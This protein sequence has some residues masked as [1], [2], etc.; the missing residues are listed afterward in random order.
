[1]KAN[2]EFIAFSKKSLSEITSIR[3]G[4]V[5]LGQKLLTMNDELANANYFILGVSEDIGPQS[6]GGFG[7]ST[8]AFSAFLKR[9]V[10]IQSNQFLIGENILVL[11]EIIS[12]VEFQN[13]NDGR[14]LVEE[15]D[16]FV[17]SILSPLIIKGL[18]P[19]VIGGGHNNAFPLIKSI[20][21]IVGKPISVINFD[22]HAD[23]RP[24][25]GRHSGNPFS[26]AF[27]QG[28]LQKYAVLGLHQSY[29]S[30]FILEQLAKNNFMFSFFDDYLLAN[31]DFN[32]DLDTFYEYI[33]DNNFGVELDLDAISY[34][35]SS[36][37]SPSGMS[38]EQARTYILKMAKSKN[39]KYLHLPEAA[40]LGEKEEVIV[41]KTLAYLVSDF[42]K[43]NSIGE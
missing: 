17:E 36:A 28:Y 30:Q 1:M 26:Y 20:S 35:P 12:N 14:K 13:I 42:I 37:F 33:N 29:N 7:G 3:N 41:G 15:L 10:N 25:E 21:K 38:V 18:I 39:V 23:F 32:S 4:E 8:T 6:N 22:P 34:M 5:K 24:L 40:P 27:D 9:F 2:F 43:T 11:G 19:I 16:L 31:V